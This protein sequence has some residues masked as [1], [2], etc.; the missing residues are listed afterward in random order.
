MTRSISPTMAPVLARLEL[1]RPRVITTGDLASL[2]DEFG[3]ATPPRIVAARLRESG[4]L[5]STGQR[6]VWEFIP[7]DQAGAIS[8]SD[9][10]LAFAAYVCTHPGSECALTFQAAAW[11]HGL[12]DRVPS[13]LEVATPSGKTARGL[14]SSLRSSVFRPALT[15]TVLRGV[16]VLGVESVLVHMAARPS[17]VRSWAT[18]VEWLPSLAA[19][20]GGHRVLAELATR[21]QTVCARTGYLLQGLRPDV[22][23]E[24]WHLRGATSR[25][26]FGQRGP[27]KQ[28]HNR[29]QVADTLLPFDPM[30]LEAVA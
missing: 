4:W 8:S 9:P 23:D 10:V 7:A 28:H 1:D 6:G 26:W 3:I 25:T 17:D 13:R 29:W 19:E 2:L 22:A 21:P 5:L 24:I 27:V 30:E 18:A 12:A 14:P 11:A 20:L 16:P 15:P